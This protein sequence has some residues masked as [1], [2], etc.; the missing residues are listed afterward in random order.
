MTDLVERL[1]D[2]LADRYLIE[3]ELGQGGMATVYLAQDIRHDRKVALKVLRAELAAILGG[4][5]FLHEIRTTANLQHPHILPLHDSGEADGIV[6]YVMPYVEGESL[7]DRLN[8]ERQLP[9][10]DAVRIAREVADA[11]DYAHRKGVIH[12]DIKP[13]NILL[14][15]G[16]AQVADFGIALAV[17]T[18]GGG[19][20][21]TETG[22]SLGTPHYMSP[23]QAMGE[24]EITPKADIYALGCVLY[25]MLAGEPPF[26]GPTAQAIVAR[27]MTEQPRALT[28]QRHTIPGHIEAAVRVA[29]EKLPADRF[30]TAAQF[31]E[32]LGRTDFALPAT[33]MS[34][35]A[36]APTTAR[37]RALG[38]VPWL[39]LL[40][41]LGGGAWGWLRPVSRPVTRQRIVLWEHPVGAGALARD[42]A[43]SPDGATLVFV[44]SV[45]GTRQLWSK[46]RDRID[47]TVLAGTV[48]AY[49]PTF[50]PD[51]AWI[52]FA[53]DGKLKKIPRLGGSS[54]TI[55]DSANMV[56]TAIA[57]LDNDTIAYN[58]SRYSLLL[59]NQDG[60][61]VRTVALV[62]SLHRGVVSAGA[63]PRGRGVLFSA[64]T[65][66]CPEVDLR[67]VDLRTGAIRVLVDQVVRAWY[68]P[69]G[70]VVFVRRDGGVFAAPFDLD[71]LAFRSPPV[72]V[73]DGVRG[74][75]FGADLALGPSGMLV[76]ISGA[77]L[78]AA[79]PAEAVWVSRQGEATPIEPGWAFLPTSN[80]GLSLSPDGRR[81]ALSTQ[82]GASQDIWIKELD[83]GPFTRLTFDGR[84][85]RPEWTANGQSVMYV[86]A[87]PGAANDLY[88]RRADGT[89]TET[90]LL[91]ASRAIWEVVRT[92]DT[93]RLVIRFTTP[94]SRD[95]ML[96]RLGTDSA[97]TPLVATAAFDEVAPALSPDG[98]W[99][100]YSS[101]ESGHY[102]VY[103]RPYPNTDGG[104]WEVSRSGGQEP[105]WSHSGRELFYRDGTGGLVSA[106]VKPGATFALGDQTVLFP[107]RAFMANDTHRQ[108]DVTP[109]DRRFVFVRL[110][111]GPA[112][113]GDTKLIMVENW[114]ADIGS[115]GQRR[116]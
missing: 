12:R 90:R 60:G 37:R 91:H 56:L 79:A 42:L 85:A 49:A 70:Q 106:A 100:A 28:I 109:D 84:N 88:T 95:L 32:A 110:V 107:A 93:T 3:R 89:G 61:P 24:R 1:R 54:V 63:L 7:R 101:N 48:G 44:D 73:L 72:P 39:L 104:R 34:P 114:L 83:R 115:G 41:A 22:M 67:V 58:D 20:R 50:S 62:D 15:D 55:A 108:Y 74:T 52:A 13:E 4:E 96:A 99:L 64:C 87:R 8:R 82:V 19:T 29:L 51:G 26:N 69:G 16:R 77:S 105:R 94:P 46:E 76:Y 78:A 36:A 6:Y 5:R 103:V 98:R 33:R 30:A 25:E 86:S 40:L 9:V 112:T 111:G 113:A 59:V 80:G 53:A 102:E 68:T 71:K 2:A 14:H 11:L 97:I 18:A 27:V 31:A 45:G 75:P 57:W 81:L 65:G 38:A 21:M 92:P 66:G 116:P 43:I 35:A 10:E 47:A 17:S 23:E